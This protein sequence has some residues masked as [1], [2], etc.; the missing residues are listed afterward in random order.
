[1]NEDHRDEAQVDG[2]SV[3]GYRDPLEAELRGQVRN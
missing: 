2:F 1:M 3:S